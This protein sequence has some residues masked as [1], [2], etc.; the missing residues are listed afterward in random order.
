MARL[1]APSIAVATGRR[2]L[3]KITACLSRSTRRVAAERPARHYQ[4][5][6]REI[7]RPTRAASSSFAEWL[8]S[9]VSRVNGGEKAAVHPSCAVTRAATYGKVLTS[10]CP[11]RVRQ[12]ARSINHEAAGAVRT[13]DTPRWV[14]QLH[15]MFLSCTYA[16]IRRPAHAEALRHEAANAQRN[17]A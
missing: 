1:Q 13:I 7:H 2:C 5:S 17:P 4:A 10:I 15:P 6:E 14:G 16:P 3:A 12:S 9:R 11:E 8:V